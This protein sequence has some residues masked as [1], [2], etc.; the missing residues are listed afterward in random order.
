MIKL[1]TERKSKRKIQANTIKNEVYWEREKGGNFIEY[2]NCVVYITVS[3]VVTR[4][5][6]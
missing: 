6:M 5:T 4:S 1:K 3:T 2:G